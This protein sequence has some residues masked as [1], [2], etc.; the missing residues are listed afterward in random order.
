[1]TVL[2]MLI[3]IIKSTFS[4]MITIYWTCYIWN[5]SLSYLFHCL[6]SD[7]DNRLLYGIAIYYLLIIIYYC[8]T[9]LSTM[10]KF[11]WIS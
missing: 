7:I 9:I 6:D 1:M 11:E 8:T 5:N 4:R 3:H 2:R 10:I